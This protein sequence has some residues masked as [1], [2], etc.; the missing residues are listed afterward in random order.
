VTNL[1]LAKKTLSLTVIYEYDSNSVTPLVRYIYN[2][3]I[4][5][6]STNMYNKA[7][8]WVIS[9]LKMLYNWYLDF[10]VLY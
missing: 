10:Y 9:G 3:Y 4:N 5:Y 1:F 8:K 2:I 6:Y 7:I